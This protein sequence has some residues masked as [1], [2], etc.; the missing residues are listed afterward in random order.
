MHGLKAADALVVIGDER[1][2]DIR[3]AIV[4]AEGLPRRRPRWQAC[5]VS[6]RST[7]RGLVC[8]G[9]VLGVV[10]PRATFTKSARKIRSAI[11]LT[12]TVA[13]AAK[14]VPRCA[15]SEGK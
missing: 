1:A 6:I 2:A 10:A 5:D 15:M 4:A 11:S 3:K 14:K 7:K 8:R 13:C 9:L 12:L